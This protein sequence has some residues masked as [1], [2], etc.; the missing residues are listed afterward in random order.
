M[1]INFKSKKTVFLAV[2]ILLVVLILDIG[3]YFLVIR[4]KAGKPEESSSERCLTKDEFADYPIDE[5]YA[6]DSV[7]NRLSGPRKQGY[8]YNPANELLQYRDI[9][10]QYNLNGNLIKKQKTE[11]DDDEKKI[12]NYQYDP[13][14]RLI[15]VIIQEYEEEELEEQKIIKYLYDPFGRRIEKRIKEIEEDDD[16]EEEETKLKV[17]QYFY[18]NEDILAIYDAKGRKV[19]LFVHGLGVDE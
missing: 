8:A 14:N 6:Y 16:E 12:T 15:Q 4:N 9:S 11:K 18:D 2:S 10:F 17:E 1:K 3:V 13:E 5:K 19:S 7:G